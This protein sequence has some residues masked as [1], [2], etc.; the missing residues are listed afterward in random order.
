[1]SS[2]RYT[3]L[4]DDLVRAAQAPP[5]RAPDDLPS[6][7]ATTVVAKLVRKQWKRLEQRVRSLPAEPVDVELHD[8]RKRAKQ[9][10]YALEAAA[11]I[12]GKRATRT[13]RRVAELQEHL[14]EHHDAVVAMDWLRT[15]VHDWNDPETAFVAGEVAESY[16]HDRRTRRETWNRLWQRARRLAPTA[17]R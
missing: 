16:A 10:R 2:A 12:L 13:A 6:G 8:V 11:P 15:R 14:G 3:A 1:M 17:W 5:L 9:A 4:L 7:D